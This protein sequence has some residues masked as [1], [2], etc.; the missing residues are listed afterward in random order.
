MMNEFLSRDYPSSIEKWRRLGLLED[1]RGSIEVSVAENLERMS[2]YLGDL[3]GKD[4]Y[5]MGYNLSFSIFPAIRRICSQNVDYQ[6][7][8]PEK[9]FNYYK[10][11]FRERIESFE[12]MP[13]IDPEAQAV[14]MFCEHTLKI[15]RKC[16][17][18]E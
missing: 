18:S 6:I 1:L 2:L 5:V 13:N 12:K 10:E 14:Y 9:F 8:E 7:E 4:V 15:L 17:E 3:E 11:W 16:A